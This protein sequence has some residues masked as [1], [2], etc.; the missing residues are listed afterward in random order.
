MKSS[1]SLKLLNLNYILM[2]DGKLSEL[3]EEEGA[4]KIYFR[5]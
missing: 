3:L 1:N 4:Y 5:N 2:N